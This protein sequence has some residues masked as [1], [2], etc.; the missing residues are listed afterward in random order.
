LLI[1][2]VHLKA[3]GNGLQGEETRASGFLDDVKR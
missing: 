3:S 1:L 2:S